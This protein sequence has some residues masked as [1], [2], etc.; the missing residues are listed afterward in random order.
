MIWLSDWVRGCSV[1]IIALRKAWFQLWRIF[2]PSPPTIWS[3]PHS[4]LNP[5]RW[6]E[7]VFPG[8][9]RSDVGLRDCVSIVELQDTLQLSV[10]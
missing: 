5:S 10:S 9:R 2:L 8:K 1:E 4:I 6:A 7:L 3:V